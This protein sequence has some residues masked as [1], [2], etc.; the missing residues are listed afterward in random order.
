MTNKSLLLALG[1]ILVAT[2]PAS[3]SRTETVQDEAKLAK[4]AAA[5]SGKEKKYCVRDVITGTRMKSRSC[6]T[7]EEW[8]R[9]GVDL[10][11]ASKK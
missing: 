5:E 10:D 3:A 6:R 8:S 2:T 7:K 4:Q 11:A 9:D 1:A